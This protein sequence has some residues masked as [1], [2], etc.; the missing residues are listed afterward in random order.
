MSLK[1][2]KAEIRRLQ[3]ENARLTKSLDNALEALRAEQSKPAQ[4]V[5][6]YQPH[7][8]TAPWTSPDYWRPWITWSTAGD[9]VEAPVNDGQTYRLL[10]G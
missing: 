3:R 4:L 5:P 7:P 9:T 2:A 8:D 10:H 1:E 6:Y